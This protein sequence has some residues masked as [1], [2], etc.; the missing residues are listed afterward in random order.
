MKK[1]QNPAPL[2]FSVNGKMVRMGRVDPNLTVLNYLRDADLCGT[3]EGCA[4]GDCGACTVVVLEPDSS[5]KPQ[6]SAVNS[7]LMLLPMAHGLE[8]WTAE[9]IGSPTAQHPVQ[10]EL[11]ERGGSQC[12]YCTPGFV[13]SLFAEYYRPNRTEAQEDALVGNLCRCTGYRP[14]R[15]ALHALEQPQQNDVFLKHLAHSKV[16][17]KPLESA[18]FMRPVTL[19]G[20]LDALEQNPD[21]RFIA[22]GTDL[23]L[24]RTTAFKDLG[25]LISLEAIPELLEVNRLTNH[26]EVGAGVTLSRL[27]GELQ[28][29]FPVLEQLWPWFASRQIRNRATLGGN[30]G[31]AS[32]I[33]DANVVLLALEAEVV[34]VRAGSSG[35]ERRTLPLSQY[36]LSYRKTALERGEIIEKIVLPHQ[37]WTHQAA[38]KVAKRGHDDISSVLGAFALELNPSGTVQ[39]A[40]LAYGGVAAIPAR[41]MQTETFLEGKTW[42]RNTLEGAKKVL[43]GEFT[44][45]SDF[46]ASKEYRSRI[47]VNLL[48]KFFLEQSEWVH[49]AG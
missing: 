1:M 20:A 29:F 24:E 7:C 36:F 42:N 25:V 15:E 35:L 30:L 18:Q 31:S 26:F 32:P 40:R 14:I 22:G 2:E 5:G 37:S 12:G 41:A 44:P 49:W 33:G 8:L 16:Q 21:A 6:F 11:G 10:L 34:L 39:K 43:E 47:V 19:E 13:M 9:G 4:E 38:Y 45:L 28:G 17:K 46:R 48:E 23:A 27:E 3:K